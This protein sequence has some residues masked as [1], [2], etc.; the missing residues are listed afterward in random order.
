MPNN[1]P[2][3]ILD[4]KDDPLGIMGDKPSGGWVK[5]PARVLGATAGSLA[6][7]PGAGIRAA[8]EL[9]P[10]ISSDPNQFFEPGSLEKAGK[11]LEDIMSVPQKLIAT[12]KEERAIETIGLAMKPFELAG[13]GWRLITEHS[14]NPIIEKLTGGKIKEVPYLE[15]VLGTAGEAAAMFAAGGGLKKVGAKIGRGLRAKGAEARLAAGEAKH[16]RVAVVPEKIK[17]LAAEA[18]VI[19]MRPES[20]FL[21]QEF[22]AR[23]KEEKGV[24]VVEKPRKSAEESAQ[25]FMKEFNEAQTPLAKD[26]LLK[27]LLKEQSEKGLE[28]IFGEKIAAIRQ[29]LSPRFRSKIDIQMEKDF[30]KFGKV[31]LTKKPTDTTLYGG[32]P[33]PEMAKAVKNVGTKIWDVGVEQKLPKLLEKIPGGKSVNRALI[34]EYRGDL[35]N[36]AKYIRSMEDKVR[37]QQVGRAYAL[38]LGNRL[39]SIPEKSQLMLGEYI[40][41]EIN[42]L[43]EN[44]RGMGNEAKLTML[45]LG[46]QA[47]DMGLLSE[48]TF[49]KNAGRYMPRLYTSKE[50]Q[51]LLTKFNLKKANRLDLSRFKRRKD[52]PKEIRQEMGEIL[53]PGYPIAKGITQLTHDIELARWF[54]SIAVNKE[55]A[56][57]KTHKGV[58]PENWKKLPENKRLGDLSEATVHPEIFT[59]LSEAVRIMDT[60]ERVWRKALGAWKFG[61]VILSPKT[62]ARNL[63]SNSILAHLGG[64]PMYEQPVY[65]TRAAKQMRLKGDYWKS[66]NKEGLLGTTWTE[67]ELNALFSDVESNIKGIKAKGIPEK[68]GII[69]TGWEKSKKLAGK[70][71]K[72]YQAE[73]EWFKLAKFIHNIERKKMTVKAAAKDAEKWLFNYQK[74]TKFQAKYR[75]RWY[76]APF[77]TFTFKALPRIAEAAVKT[78]HRFILPGAMIYGLERAAMNM[79]GDS[80]EQFKAKKELRSEW[81][82]GNFLGIPNFARVPLIDDSGRE[83]YLN[84]TYTLP[85]GDIGESGSFAGI[86]GALMPL[87]QPFVKESWQQIANYDSFW[88]KPIVPEEELA[89]KT[90]VGKAKT[91]VAK[92]GKHLIQTMAPTLVLDVKKGI[93]AFRGRP[94]YKGRTRPIG[95][96]AAD[97]FLGIK[98]YPVDYVE[99]MV[100]K[101][102]KLDPNK[103]YLA[104]KI[105]GQIKTLEIKRKAVDK[106]GKNDEYYREKIEEKIEQLRGLGKELKKVGTTYKKI[107]KLKPLNPTG[108][109][110]LNF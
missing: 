26:L 46:K 81:M 34:Y 31:D 60:P 56:L 48:K 52:I 23:F 98:L 37:S 29:E 109:K 90:L 11:V 72:T 32:L 42:T 97:A 38:D 66:A 54:K 39:Q 9:L 43:P 96:V 91:Q 105:R 24:K 95:V 64:M 104:R 59:D 74:V 53:T 100:R 19:P 58:I 107:K 108:L 85:W 86:P 69:G 57:P 14:I 21:K 47:V 103:G 22:E 110:E 49:F 75:S 41:G 16:G 3:G 45:D 88:G 94:D 68:L 17:T 76:G 50:Y 67:H 106:K 44:L 27:K 30:A 102:N 73:E 28:P 62:H 6:L 8:I 78:P 10:K 12:P 20:E 36:T 99:Q 65:L 83:Y 25:V 71:A 87:S 70:A 4:V 63:M 61:K 84:L 33:I 2:L 18:K 77:A 40:R 7:F 55:W 80:P 93:E 101:V 79:I 13:E 15:P 82:Q 35:P 51:T 92:R 89:G 1:D 5:S